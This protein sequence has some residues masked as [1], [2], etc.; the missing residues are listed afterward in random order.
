MRRAQEKGLAA[1]VNLADLITV[2]N[3]DGTY[4]TQAAY[5]VTNR[6]RQFLEIGLPKES[7]LWS[8]YVA[9]QPVRPATVQRS[10]R[11][12]MLVPL[13]KISVGDLSAQVVVVYSG[14]LGG[15]L[16][17][18]SDVT[19]P[20]PEIL[21]Q[22]PVARSLWTVYL[23][24]DYTARFVEKT[25]NMDPAGSGDLTIARDLA[26]FEEAN[27]LLRV[28]KYSSNLNAKSV[29]CDRLA[30]LNPA[31]PA[32]RRQA[33]TAD[34]G[35]SL[36]NTQMWRAANSTTFSKQLEVFLCP[37]DRSDGVIQL[38]RITGKENW[39]QVQQQAQQLQ[40]EI[41]KLQRQVHLAA[42][43][44][45]AA[46]QNVSEY[47]KQYFV[48]TTRSEGLIETMDSKAASGKPLRHFGAVT[49]EGAERRDKLREQNIAQLGVLK[50]GQAQT[51]STRE[52]GPVF[53]SP[54]SSD[55]A[56]EAAG[57]Q[58]A[59][60]GGV[61]VWA[62]QVGG[63]ATS[64]AGGTDY[65]SARAVTLLQEGVTTRPGNRSIEISIP[66]VGRAHHFSKLLGDPK[67]VLVARHEDLTRWSASAAWAVLC[68]ALVAA[69][70]YV[71]TRPEAA[72]WVR[73][74]WPGL[75]AL[76][77]GAWWFLLPYGFLGLGLVVTG[78]LVLA[79]RTRSSR[80]KPAPAAAEV[81]RR[82]GP[83]D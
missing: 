12:V 56:S 72:S 9:G 24:E 79:W 46:R 29:A 81:T 58:T 16:G 74:G 41:E 2:V 61:T 17:R 68:L 45:E 77:G 42:M 32:F 62:A 50:E 73:R 20:A 14:T 54:P 23:P 4:R 8:V 39:N 38:G 26:F 25:S 5:V 76:L 19:P 11:G 49:N 10:G 80:S 22:V 75:A 33:I 59:R 34:A 36:G 69:I 6:T 40:G 18:W 7:S 67:L 53:Q 27:E 65:G 1:S 60:P 51:R 15:K 83:I 82:V 3:R 13:Q 47:L 30:Q 52:S 64:P 43:P 37:S 63:A 71:P 78:L 44:Q 31:L 57:P 55:F 28:A 21:D 35:I 70:A 66:T 48:P